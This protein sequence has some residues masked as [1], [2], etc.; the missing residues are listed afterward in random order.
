MSFQGKHALNRIF[1]AE[2]CAQLSKND[3]GKGVFLS[4]SGSGNGWNILAAGCQQY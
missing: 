1:C 2:V 4:E 3:V